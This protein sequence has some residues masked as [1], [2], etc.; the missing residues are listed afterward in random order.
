MAAYAASKSMDSEAKNNW[1]AV[2]KKTF[3]RWANNKLKK[4]NMQFED[5]Y[6]DFQDGV[7]PINLLEVIGGESVKTVLNVKYNKKPKM[8]IQKLE[9][10]NHIINYCKAKGVDFVNV[11]ANDFVDGNARIILGFLWKVILRFVVS[12]DGQQGLLLWCQR[13]TKPYDNIKIKNFHRSWQD[14]LGFVGIIHRYRPD[15]IADPTTLDPENAAENCELAFS[16]AEEKLGIP[17]LL[18]VEDIVGTAKPDDKSIATYMNEFYLLFATALQAEHYIQ[19]IIKACAVTRR[20]DDMIARYNSGG[21]DLAAWTQQMTERYSNFEYGSTTDQ[22][23]DQLMGF[24][25]YRNTDKPPR[26]GQLIDL[27]GT[28][29]SLRSSCNSNNRPVFEP[30]EEIAPAK[31]E[32][33]WT[34]LEALENDHEARLRELYATFQEIDFAIEKFS[35]RAEKLERWVTE[36][37]DTF[38]DADFGSG[39]VGA[40]ISLNG[41]E[42]YERQ[43]EKYKKAAEDL[44]GLATRCGEVPAHAG[45]AAVVERNGVL[46]DALSQLEQAGSAYKTALDEHLAR[47]QRLAQ[48]EK[49]VATE[50]AIAIYDQDD[51]SSRIAEP[52]VAGQVAAVQ[53]KIAELNGPVADEVD[54][55]TGRV[56]ALKGKVDELQS[57][58]GGGGDA[59]PDDDVALRRTSSTASAVQGA[60]QALVTGDGA[61]SRLSAELAERVGQLEAKLAEETAKE[62][63]RRNFADAANAVRGECEERTKQLTALDGEP[64]D[65]LE[66]LDELSK[67]HSESTIMEPA[68]A[69]SKASE[70]AGVVINPYTPETIFTLRSQWEELGKAYK[71]ARNIA[72][73]A[74]MDKA[75]TQLT[76]EQIAEIREVFDYFDEDKD[77]KLSLKEF[78]DGLQ[79]MGLVM[80]EETS[81]RDFA[82]LN[83]GK[84]LTFDQF[85]NYMVDKMKTGSTHPDVIAA[86]RSLVN[87]EDTISD[88]AITQHFGAHDDYADYLQT[89]IQEG[90]YI[91]FTDDLFTR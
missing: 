15:L 12:E 85:S 83:A 46:A 7:L 86:F 82:A 89:N 8:K 16:V 41:F 9:N 28:L 51:L 63:L 39:V 44:A 43:L 84:E 57:L 67:G 74:I 11:G 55:F 26:A 56:A 79:G 59:G 25:E 71:Q 37:S 52:V 75:G 36:K 6:T 32:G 31:L 35:G 62:E 1:I 24:Y 78:Q 13:S 53:D 90:A 60:I 50:G 87:N 18:D 2:Q 88:E 73:K 17:R 42:I 29:N 80:D 81:E 65:Q 48:L 47:E 45:S 22:I 38:E 72:E 10:G 4:K 64:E 68:E 14:G 49:E 76:P 21:A 70:D 34:D 69:A 5:L 27:V 66:A 23:R 54:G 58:T 3:T 91:P 77:G 19:A 61:G 20:H 33:G 30:A 40:E